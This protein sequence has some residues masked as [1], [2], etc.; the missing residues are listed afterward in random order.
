MEKTLERALFASR[1]LMAPIYV[2]LII[3]LAVLVLKF[4]QE[5]LH[6]V[7]HIFELAEADVVLTALT[8]AL[9]LDVR[10]VGD[11]GALPS[12][13]P[14]FLIPDVPF[15]LET[16]WIILPYSIGVAVALEAAQELMADGIDAEVID[17]RTL[18]PLDKATVLES[19]KRTN[20]MVVVEEGWPTCSI[21]SEIM[22]I[23]MSEGFDDLDAPVLRVTNADVPL[24][25]AANLEKLALIGIDDVLATVRREGIEA[26]G[27]A[28][29]A[30]DEEAF[31]A[32]IREQYE[33]QGH[34][35]YSSARLW[36]D[37]VIDPADTRRV[38]AL[39]LSASL[40][41]PIPPTRFGL[42]RM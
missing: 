19:L 29:S 26:R 15:N 7:P 18:R 22:A 32:P 6:F 5:L 23:A 8:L 40:N 2:G 31:K 36:D 10:T 3:T 25:Y 38:L 39:G 33:T 16:L 13:L 35:Y 27:G 1:W 12:S 34:P 17:L 9:G 21:A 37:G 30:E 11:L 41:A 14:T 4:L 24:P 42:F 28:W 20:R